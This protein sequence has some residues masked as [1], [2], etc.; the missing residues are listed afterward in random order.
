MAMN[1]SLLTKRGQITV[2]LLQMEI[3]KFKHNLKDCVIL[4]LCSALC[5]ELHGH[6]FCK[7]LEV[8]GAN[9]AL[10]DNRI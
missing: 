5:L 8:I 10:S 9:F 3:A 6:T 1:T 4:Q 7:P 2:M